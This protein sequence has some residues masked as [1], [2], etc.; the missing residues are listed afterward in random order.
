MA[1]SKV[2]WDL[3]EIFPSPTDPSLQRA[4][5]EVT[6]MAEA[7]AANYRGKIGPLTAKDFWQTGIKE[8]MYF[9]N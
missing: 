1:G 6:A 5:D 2:V 7:F 9:L 8:Y 4:I 3:P